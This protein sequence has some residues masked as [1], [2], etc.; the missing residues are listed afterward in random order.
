MCRRWATVVWVGL[1]LVI[2]GCS[3]AP[4][5]DEPPLESRVKA[6]IVYKLGAFVRWPGEDGEAELSGFEICILGDSPVGR[7]LL[8][9]EGRKLHQRPVTVHRLERSGSFL[10]DC[11]ILF[12][13]QRGRSRF[14]ALLPRIASRPILTVSDTPG[15]AKAGGIVELYQS[16]GRVR[17]KV[18]VDAARRAGLEIS[19]QVLG[20]ATIVREEG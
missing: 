16:G 15:F 20:L 4:A 9:V 18:N 8:E 6:A 7:A 1:W 13:S 19:A 10:A 3:P 17:L 12:I 5:A 14:H 2:L 11:E